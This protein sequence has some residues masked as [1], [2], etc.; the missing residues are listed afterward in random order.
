MTKKMKKTYS[1]GASIRKPLN[2]EKADLDNNKV[3]SE[4]ERKRG[5][6]IEKAMAK[7]KTV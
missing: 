5:I 7:R 2:F 4:Y 6:A 3:L 1:N